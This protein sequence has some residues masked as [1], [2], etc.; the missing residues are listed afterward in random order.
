LIPH[1][2]CSVADS[3]HQ[4]WGGHLNKARVNV[5]NEITIL[6]LDKLNLTRIKNEETGLMELNIEEV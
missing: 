4:L 6:K 5:I 1:I 2:H 3:E